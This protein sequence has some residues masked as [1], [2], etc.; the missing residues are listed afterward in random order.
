MMKHL[1]GLDHVVIKVRDLSAAA[2]AWKRL[3][4]TLSTW[5]PATTH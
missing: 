2:D 3:G 4:F 5:A 1:L